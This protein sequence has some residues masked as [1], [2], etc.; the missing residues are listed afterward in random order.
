MT[1]GYAFTMARKHDTQVAAWYNKILREALEE[2]FEHG[3][4][5]PRCHAYSFNYNRGEYATL[6]IS[7]DADS[8]SNPIKNEQSYHSLQVIEKGV[9]GALL[10]IMFISEGTDSSDPENPVGFLVVSF[11]DRIRGWKKVYRLTKEHLIDQHD[12]TVKVTDLQYDEEASFSTNIP[13]LEKYSHILRPNYSDHR[14]L[15]YN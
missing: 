3:Y 9:D 13:M 14:D 12:S 4:V 6:T 11:E 1:S 2:I 15:V 5:L 8:L 7:M 10:G